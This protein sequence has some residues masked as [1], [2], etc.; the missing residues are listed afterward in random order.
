MVIDQAISTSATISRR[1]F[2]NVGRRDLPES[3]V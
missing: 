2:T 1:Q 3:Y